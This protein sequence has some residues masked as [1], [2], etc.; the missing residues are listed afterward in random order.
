MRKVTQPSVISQGALIPLAALCDDL[1]FFS[2]KQ[3]EYNSAS[4][5]EHGRKQRANYAAEVFFFRYCF[6]E[7]WIDRF[8]KI[9]YFQYSIGII[10]DLFFERKESGAALVDGMLFSALVFVCVSL[11]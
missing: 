10:M 6:A 4:V 9:T 7:V 11:L 5:L 8:E 1:A 3:Y 2:S